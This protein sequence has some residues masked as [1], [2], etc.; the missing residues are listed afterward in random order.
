LKFPEVLDSTARA[1]FVACP[2]KFF[3][4]N[5]ERLAPRRVSPDLLAGGAY[6]VGLE[7]ARKEFYHN[8]KTEAEAVALGLEALVKHYG[9]EDPPE[10]HA[11]TCERMQSA[12]LHY[13]LTWPFESDFLR[14]LNDSAVEFTFAVPLPIN[15]PETG[16]PLI[17]AGRFDMLA[18]DS[19]GKLYCLDD[20]TTKA[21]GP[22]WAQQWALRSQFTG[23]CWAAQQY[24]HNI[25]TC[26]IRGISIQKTM[27]NTQQ[28]IVYRSKWMID[29]WFE[30]LL[31]DIRR[32][33]ACYHSKWWDY[34]LDG[35]CTSYGACIYSQLC[36]S[37]QP[38]RWY[39][40]YAENT[41]NPL[42]GTDK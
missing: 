9:P 29:R 27:H 5:V 3:Y 36:E 42:A 33:L 15:H 31:R 16:E 10:G 14:P 20:K 11:K 39:D 6:A 1:Q 30:Q 7:V 4:A 18:V 41:W 22:Q 34:N 13:T 32:M 21:I 2:R 12:L 26:I 37:P 40:L 35:E 23:Y 28:A 38:E 17:Y 8:G 25:D 24:G 19:T